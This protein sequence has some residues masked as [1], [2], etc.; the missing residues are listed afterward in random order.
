MPIFAPY[1]SLLPPPPPF[2]PTPDR[3]WV[4][5]GGAWGGYERDRYLPAPLHL[6][7]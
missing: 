3:G 6:P 2:L 4:E 5:G 7:P 1:P